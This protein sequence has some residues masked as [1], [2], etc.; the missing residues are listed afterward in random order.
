LNELPSGPRPADDTKILASL[1]F[2]FLALI[3]LAVAPLLLVSYLETQNERMEQ[4]TGRA[5]QINERL[6]LVLHRE[7]AEL[8]AYLLTRDSISLTRYRNNRALEDSLFLEVRRLSPRLDD[9]INHRVQR[10]RSVSQRWHVLADSVIDEGVTSERYLAHVREQLAFSDSTFGASAQL[11]NALDAAIDSGLQR[12]QTLGSR[13]RMAAIVLGVIALAAAIMV[14][15]FAQR[16][17]RLTT[18]LAGAVDVERSLRA[19]SEKRREEIE[20][21]TASRAR[22]MRGFSHDVKNPLGAADGYL[23]L[24]EDGIVGE[25]SPAQQESI[26][27]ARRSLRTALNLIEDLLDLARAEAGQ[28]EIQHTPFDATEILHEVADDYRAQAEAKNLELTLLPPPPRLTITG[29]ATRIRQVLS[30]LVSNAVKYTHTGSIT[31]SATFRRRDGREGEWLVIDVT[32]TGAG[33]PADKLEHIF[34][35]FSRLEPGAAKGAGVGLAISRRIAKAMD[36]EIM[37]VS[38]VG[39]GSTFSLYLP[40]NV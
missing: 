4:T 17:R 6:R 3:G 9:S 21:V 27:R 19:E 32:D 15:W 39:R 5:A 2:V 13:T 30:N 16:Q 34:Q 37:V 35:E 12:A 8:R 7:V 20:R 33:V 40:R 23:Q 29:D 1:L 31:I 11:Q 22:L 24:M 28:I 14:G 36:A 10:L 25:A 18:Q 26:G 38:E